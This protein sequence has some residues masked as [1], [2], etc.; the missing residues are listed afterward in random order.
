MA[1]HHDEAVRLGLFGHEGVGAEGDDPDVVQ[2]CETARVVKG[3][4]EPFSF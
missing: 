2:P 3:P 1:A 4:L